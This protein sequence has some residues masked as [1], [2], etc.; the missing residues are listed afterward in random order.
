MC[1]SII[2]RPVDQAHR[3][4]VVKSRHAVVALRESQTDGHNPNQSNYNL[5]RG[6]GE[7]GLQGVDDGHVPER[8]RFKKKLDSFMPLLHGVRHLTHRT[9]KKPEW[10][11][12]GLFLRGLLCHR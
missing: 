9:I 10:L 6:G 2:V 5:C 4:G 12:K 11:Y 7:A 3:P 1:S 8:R